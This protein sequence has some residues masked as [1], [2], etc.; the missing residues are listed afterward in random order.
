MEQDIKALLP[1]T[2]PH[3][4]KAFMVA[5]TILPPIVTGLLTPKMI[6]D[7]KTDLQSRIA[8]L[9]IPQETK[10]SVIAWSKSEDTYFGPAD[11]EEI[12]NNLTKPKNDN[13]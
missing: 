9:A 13:S 2:C 5:Y 1:A 4:S 12:I 11:V 3:C 7:A 6:E 8:E 10:D